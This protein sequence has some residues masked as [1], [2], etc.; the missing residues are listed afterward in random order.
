M[1][2]FYKE[3]DEDT[4]KSIDQAKL[5]EWMGENID[6]I[7]AKSRPLIIKAAEEADKA[8]SMNSYATYNIFKNV[9]DANFDYVMNTSDTTLLLNYLD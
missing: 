4:D 2:K 9:F 3:V 7:C 1:S 6:T 8:A 5:S